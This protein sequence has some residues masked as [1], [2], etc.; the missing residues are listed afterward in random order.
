MC[1]LLTLDAS[2]VGTPDRRPIGGTISQAEFDRIK[3]SALG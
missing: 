1:H 3:Q 2:P